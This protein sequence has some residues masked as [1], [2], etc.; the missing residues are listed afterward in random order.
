MDSLYELSS[1]AIRR[2]Y[3]ARLDTPPVLDI[4][5]CF[6]AARRFEAAWTQLREEAQDVLRSATSIPRFHEIM[7]AQAEIS[8]TDGRDW[9][10]FLLK[11]YGQELRAN[12]LRCPV[13]GELL[14]DTPEAISATLSFLAPHKHIPQH[15]GPFRGILRYQLNLDVPPDGEGRPG[16]VLWLA[17]HE[18][19]FG[20]GQ[21][22]LWDDTYPHEVW[23][24]SESTRIALLLDVYR[25]EMPLDLRLLSRTITAGVGVVA[26]LRGF[27]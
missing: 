14:A 8:A 25:P 13:L 22:L 9:R 3:D 6:P 17:G 10:M 20:A 15:R 19:R 2:L 27:S 12:L 18:H 24:H 4:D 11:V 23:N 7:P 21:S 16:A 5:S 26:R 1:R